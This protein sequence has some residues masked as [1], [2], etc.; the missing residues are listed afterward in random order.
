APGKWRIVDA[1]DGLAR[2]ECV[3]KQESLEEM[4]RGLSEV[5][6]E[7]AGLRFRREGPTIVGH[8][9]CT[10]EDVKIT[11]D[12]RIAGALMKTWTSEAVARLSLPPGPELE[13]VR[14]RLRATRLGAC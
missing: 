14:Q 12:I 6:L 3:E 9:I 5:D 10:S 13:T 11:M 8:G 4:V 2:E 1:D 7:C